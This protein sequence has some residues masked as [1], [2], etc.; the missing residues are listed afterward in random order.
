VDARTLQPLPSLLPSL[1]SSPR[2]PPSLAART[3]RGGERR[4]HAMAP[5][6]RER[7]ELGWRARHGQGSRDA[8]L[9]LAEGCKG[10]R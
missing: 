7:G 1:H 10:A 5:A 8:Q 3:A 4:A 2:L 6:E 9:G